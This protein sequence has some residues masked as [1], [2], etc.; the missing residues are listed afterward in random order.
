VAL[1]FPSEHARAEGSLSLPNLVPWSTAGI[2]HED[3]RDPARVIMYAAR[4]AD[5]LPLP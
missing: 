4:R 1:R 5:L 3:E 2:V